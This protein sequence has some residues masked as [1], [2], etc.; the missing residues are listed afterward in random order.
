MRSEMDSPASELE[1]LLQRWRVALDGASDPRLDLCSALVQADGPGFSSAL[2]QYLNE[3]GEEF[4]AQGE[5]LPP[6]RQ[7]TEGNLSVEGLGLLRM[8]DGKG[9]RAGEDF[10]HV[11]EVARVSGPRTYDPEAWRVP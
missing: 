2:G 4:Q 9:L 10:I 11:P 3:R 8:G 6:E 7:A 5:A 1:G